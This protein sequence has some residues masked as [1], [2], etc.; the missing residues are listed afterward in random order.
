MAEIKRE[1]EIEM[2]KKQTVQGAKIKINLLNSG[3]RNTTAYHLNVR[4][5]EKL[6]K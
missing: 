6:Q 4:G 5:V 3:H 1:T 2:K